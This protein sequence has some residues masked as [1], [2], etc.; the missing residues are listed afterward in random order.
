MKRCVMCG[1]EMLFGPP[2]KLTCSDWC[3]DKR[4]REQRQKRAEAA[5]KCGYPS[6]QAMIEALRSWHPP[7]MH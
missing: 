4:L 5:R 1:Y 6:W 2:N 7:A 3:N